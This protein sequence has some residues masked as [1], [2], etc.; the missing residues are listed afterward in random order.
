MKIRVIN[1]YSL[2]NAMLT[3]QQD[4]NAMYKLQ[5]IIEHRSSKRVK[6]CIKDILNAI[7]ND[8]LLDVISKYCWNIKLYVIIIII[9]MYV[10]KTQ[11][12]KSTQKNRMVYMTHQYKQTN[13]LLQ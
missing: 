7:N 9:K 11:Q 13:I 6:T 3:T 10:H 8:Y 4:S 1:R 5:I 2:L 12:G